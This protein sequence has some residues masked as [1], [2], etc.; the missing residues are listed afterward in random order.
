MTTKQLSSEQRL[1]PLRCS[2]QEWA[3]E[4][5]DIAPCQA[6]HKPCTYGLLLSSVM[7]LA[8]RVRPAVQH[9]KRNQAM[10]LC[11]RK[12][13]MATKRVRVYHGAAYL[14]HRNRTQ[15]K[16]APSA[17]SFV[18]YKV[19]KERHARTITTHTRVVKSNRAPPPTPAFLRCHKNVA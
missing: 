8:S 1:K 12:S 13:C 19:H 5:R 7:L 6:A 15:N 3:T 11:M 10:G 14:K 2:S 4:P 17:H 18:D 9:A 16:P